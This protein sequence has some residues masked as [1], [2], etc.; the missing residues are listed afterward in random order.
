M[1]RLGENNTKSI[2]T[3]NDW[4]GI[5]LR[6]V[7]PNVVKKTTIRMYAETMNH[8]ILGALGDRKLGEITEKTIQD[9]IKKL[10]STPVT[11]TRNGCMTEG[12][13]R[14]TLSVLS[15][16]MRDAQKYGLIDRNPCVESAWTLKSKNV[17]E[18]QEWLS[19]E[20]IKELEPLIAGYQD[21]DGYPLGLGFQLVLY[22]G[23]TLS[24]AAALR[25][26]DVNFQEGTIRLQYFVA[27]KWEQKDRTEKRKQEL[28]KLTGRKCREVLV[29]EFLMRRLL[30]V[31]NEFGGEPENFVLCRSAMEPVSMDRMRAALLRKG[32]SCH[33]EAITPRML[34]DTYA[35]RAV[36]AGATSDMIA[37]VMGFASSKQV[38]R[39]Y[40]P[41]TV[42]DKRELMKKM[43]GE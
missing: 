6:D 21:E 40:M 43:F 27:V 13:V 8:H 1:K 9:W 41:K 25:W 42:T 26:R 3:L 10:Q 35:M 20:Q 24:E 12:T 17:G 19:E 23:I 38:I 4:V 36:Q 37:E 29:P 18:K 30:Q 39:R 32:R 28:E 2:D 33:M 5:W 11:G 14:N 31:R 34:R 16:C 22:T 15:G 7:L